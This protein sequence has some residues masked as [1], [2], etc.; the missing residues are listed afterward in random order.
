MELPPPSILEIGAITT[1]STAAIFDLKHQKIPNLLTFPAAAL[2]VCLRFLLLAKGSFLSNEYIATAF[3]AAGEGLLTWFIIV[4]IM[5]LAKLLM[6]KL[7][8]GDT[9]LFAAIGAFV[10]IKETILIFIFFGLFFGGYS[11]PKLAL[12]LPWKEILIA[13][14]LR[15]AGVRAGSPALDK[16]D[17]TRQESLPLAPFIAAATIAAVYLR[18]P[19]GRL[20]GLL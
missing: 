2:A 18:E 4:I 10:G 9:K 1:A 11:L 15:Q 12:S 14:H 6:P 13:L 8:H 17:Q 7:G 20:L 5:S 16:F 3:S 19:A